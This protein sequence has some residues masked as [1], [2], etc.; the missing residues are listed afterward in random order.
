MEDLTYETDSMSLRDGR[1]FVKWFDAT[2]GTDRQISG[3]ERVR[4]E[5]GNEGIYITCFELTQSE[6]DLLR[7]YE[8]YEGDEY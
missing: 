4:D 3:D 7:M 2:I 1:D 6:C 8:Y 5:D